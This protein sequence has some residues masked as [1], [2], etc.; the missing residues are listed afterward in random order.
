LIPDKKILVDCGAPE[1][2]D[3]LIRLGERWVHTNTELDNEHRPV[4]VQAGTQLVHGDTP[5]DGAN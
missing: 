4:P 3:P 2:G 5:V 1:C